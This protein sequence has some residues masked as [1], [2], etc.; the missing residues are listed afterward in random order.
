M[1]FGPTDFGG[2]ICRGS[3]TCHKHHRCYKLKLVTI[4]NMS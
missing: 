4:S 3:E 2:L 1:A